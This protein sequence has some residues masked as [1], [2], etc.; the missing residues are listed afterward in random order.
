MDLLQ[1]S[2]RGRQRQG[3]GVVVGDGARGENV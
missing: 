1:E 2:S 3:Q